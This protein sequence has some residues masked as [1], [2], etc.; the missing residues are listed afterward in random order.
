MI[1]AFE[2]IIG[3]KVTVDPNSHLIGA[4]GVAILAKK[5]QIEKIFDFKIAS[6]D[7]ITRGAECQ[8]CANNCEIICIYEGERFI[9][10]WGNKCDRGIVRA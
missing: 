3:Y 2:E 1:K 8:R 4:L 9:D 5:S 6:Y 10:A 7:F